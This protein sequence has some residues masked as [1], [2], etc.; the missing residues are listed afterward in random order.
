MNDPKTPPTPPEN[1]LDWFIYSILETSHPQVTP[2][3]VRG[4]YPFDSI[5]SGSV[6][7]RV[8]TFH[9]QCER[10]GANMAML[11]LVVNLI[12]LLM[13]QKSGEK[14]TVWM[15][16]KPVVNGGIDYQAQLVSRISEAQPFWTLKYRSD[17]GRLYRSLW[18]E[19]FL[20]GYD[21]KKKFTLTYT[22]KTID[23]IEKCKHI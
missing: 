1:S 10:L 12:I 11:C 15:V 13:V 8:H 20:N 22:K 2:E 16:L 23:N 5:I 14:S 21:T 9:L 18:F 7:W 3:L 17:T 19:Y 4:I 6:G